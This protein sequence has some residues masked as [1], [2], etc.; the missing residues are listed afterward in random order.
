[1]ELLVVIAIIGLM[2][3]AA[4]SSLNPAKEK[5]KIAST[6]SQ[7]HQIENAFHLFNEKYMDIPPLPIHTDS[8]NMGW[9]FPTGSREFNEWKTGATPEADW[10]KVVDQLVAEG[11]IQENIRYDQWGRVF[12]YDKNYNMGLY[13]CSSWSP[14]CSLGPD[15]I[16]QTTNN[17]PSGAPLAAGDDVCIFYNNE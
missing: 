9:F 14:I 10:N 4:F 2:L 11:F 15:G 12:V 5:G 1:M 13:T 3:T 17:C 7:L 16:L 6:R 8:F